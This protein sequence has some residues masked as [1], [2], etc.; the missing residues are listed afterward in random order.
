MKIEKWIYQTGLFLNGAAL[1]NCE[2]NPIFW[3]A[4]LF[5]KACLKY[6]LINYQI[7]HYLRALSLKSF[8]KVIYILLSYLPNLLTF[9]P[10]IQLLFWK[11]L[12]SCTCSIE[13]A[14][15]F[16][17]NMT[18]R[19]DAIKR[20]WA[21]YFNDTFPFAYHQGKKQK[22]NVTWVLEAKN[23]FI[24]LIKVSEVSFLLLSSE[25]CAWGTLYHSSSTPKYYLHIV[26]YSWHD[27][28]FS[29]SLQS[30]KISK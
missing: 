17:K 11:S 18:E 10:V 2:N 7:L 29:S 13:K 25:P 23:S 21:F 15:H 22:T 5:C 27:L 26:E 20:K 8:Y 3:E 4:R 1:L 19:M 9:Y 24:C 16:Q 6:V 30:T 28:P 12:L 14:R